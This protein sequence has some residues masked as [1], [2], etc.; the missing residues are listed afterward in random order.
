[1]DDDDFSVCRAD[2]VGIFK[3]SVAVVA[4]Q[5]RHGLAA[6]ECAQLLDLSRSGLFLYAGFLTGNGPNDGWFNY[7]PYA[8]RDYNPGRNEDFY[9]LGV[10]F[11]GISTTAGAA[12]FIVTAFRTRAPGMSSSRSNPGLGTLT[13]SAANLVVVPAV[14]LAFFLLWLDRQFGTHFFD[15]PAG[16]SR[17]CGNTFFGYSAIPGFTR[18]YCLPWAWYRMDCRCSAVVP[19]SVIPLSLCPRSPR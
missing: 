19:W 2:P 1:M 12:N 16:G 7:V 9:S 6:P 15:P 13:A 18:S 8:G 4:R 11:L 14:S 10:V 5:P 17:S 3:L